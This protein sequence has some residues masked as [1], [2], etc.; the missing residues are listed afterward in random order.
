MGKRYGEVLSL[1]AYT[2]QLQLVGQAFDTALDVIYADWEKH[3]SQLAFIPRKEHALLLYGSNGEGFAG[4]NPPKTDS[5]IDPEAIL[6]VP[7]DI[8]DRTW[9]N[10]AI[11]YE[12]SKILGSSPYV[13]DSHPSQGLTG[14]DYIGILS[15]LEAV[16]NI[17]KRSGVTLLA[18]EGSTIPD[19]VRCAGEE[20]GVNVNVF[21]INALNLS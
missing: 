6:G 13:D 10:G 11:L 20:V 2:Q 21:V 5:D 19:I 3:E 16:K 7:G 1:Q 14:T 18:Y 17:D 12:L 8:I 9:W 15:T 4:V